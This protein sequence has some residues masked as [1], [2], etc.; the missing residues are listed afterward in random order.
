MPIIKNPV[1]RHDIDIALSSALAGVSLVGVFLTPEVSLALDVAN[2]AVSAYHTTEQTRNML[3]DPTAINKVGF[4]LDLVSD[5][6][7]VLSIYAGISK[8]VQ[9]TKYTKAEKTLTSLD[10]EQTKQEARNDQ[11]RRKTQ[12]R[13]QQ[14][15]GSTYYN[16]LTKDI[17]RLQNDANFGIHIQKSINNYEKEL[18]ELERAGILRQKIEYS[19]NLVTS[20]VNI[21]DAVQ[22]SKNE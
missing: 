21:F 18:I 15:E 16:E 4:S 11:I 17:E 20:G 12:L 13:N 9:F 8:I 19:L 22:L 7:G 1:I 3:Q 6:S 2:T 5:L 14:S 10:E